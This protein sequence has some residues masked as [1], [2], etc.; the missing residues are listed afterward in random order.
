MVPSAETET[1]VRAAVPNCTVAWGSRPSPITDMYEPGGAEGGR[2]VLTESVFAAAAGCW[3][4]A[5]EDPK[6]NPK[7]PEKTAIRGAVSDPARA[8]P[9]STS[10][11]RAPTPKCRRYQV[12]KGVSKKRDCVRLRMIGIKITRAMRTS[13]PI[14]AQKT[15]SPEPKLAGGKPFAPAD[16]LGDGESLTCPITTA[17]PNRPVI[18]CPPVTLGT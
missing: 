7:S 16:G 6:I 18:S 13:T 4:R 15:R 12:I 10:R 8:S 5:D 2:T 3:A 11:P 17:A 1:S 9:I 14:S